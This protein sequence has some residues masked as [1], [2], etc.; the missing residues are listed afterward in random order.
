MKTI[1]KGFSTPHPNAKHRKS[2]SDLLRW[3]ADAHLVPYVYM[4][5]IF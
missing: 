5:N 3:T 2:C 4:Q 1:I